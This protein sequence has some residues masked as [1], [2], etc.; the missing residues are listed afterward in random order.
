MS[1]NI[2]QI[3]SKIS[4]GMRHMTELNQ[5]K[6][7][8]KHFSSVPISSASKS[9]KCPG[10]SSSSQ[11]DEVIYVK[12]DM[13]S[14]QVDPISAVIYIPTVDELSNNTQ[15]EIVSQFISA[16]DFL[17]FNHLTVRFA[18]SDGHC[19]MHAWAIA[20]G[21]SIASIHYTIID[22]YLMNRQVYAAFGV[23][24]QDLHTYLESNQFQLQSV[25]TIINILCN[26]TNITA[27]IVEE[28]QR[29]LTDFKIIRPKSGYSL[30]TI[31]LLRKAEHYDAIV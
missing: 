25:D 9:T 26:G 10:I 21:S 5:P 31:L 13:A 2:K 24:E 11:K 12:H 23:T 20:T 8:V 30:Q 3:K 7:H 18:R 6:L 28:R 29:N 16:N 1:E 22:E 4:D 14:T 17:Q 19:I 15:D 27:I